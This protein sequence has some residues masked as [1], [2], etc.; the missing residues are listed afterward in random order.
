MTADRLYRNLEHRFDG[1][2]PDHLRR[3][4]LAGGSDA[5][6]RAAQNATSR[7]CDRQALLALGNAAARLA[8]AVDLEHWRRQGLA[9]RD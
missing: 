8:A 4:A 7:A 6:E 2:I 3:L 5:F 1:E 9:R